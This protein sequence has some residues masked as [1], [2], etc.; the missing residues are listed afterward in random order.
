[1]R[2]F[3]WFER[4]ERH[5]LHDKR[6][7]WLR[8][9]D[10]QLIE[11]EMLSK[12]ERQYLDKLGV[13]LMDDAIKPQKANPQFDLIHGFFEQVRAGLAEYK[14][15]LAKAEEPALADLDRLAAR[16]YCRPLRA[17]EA[18]ALRGLY[19]R[20]RKQGHGV[21]ASLRG[22]FTAVLM[23]PHFFYRVP[24]TPAGKGVYPLRD[25]AMARRISYFLWSS[26]P[27]D[28][29]LKSARAGELQDGDVLRTQVR[30]MMKD[31]KIEALAREFFGQWLRYRD[32]PAKDT[33][34]AKTFPGYDADLRAA[35]FEEPTRLITHLLQEDNSVDELLH[36]DA[37]FVNDT[38]ARFY[39]G[40]IEKQY[41]Q[42]AGRA[43]DGPKR[44]PKSEWH[45]VEGLRDIGRG[46]LFGMPVILATNSVGA[47]TSPVKRGFW[48]VHHVLGQH[49]PPPPAEVP[50]LPKSEK[51]SA[52]TIREMLA[53]HTTKQSCAMCHVH[54][55][56]LGLTMEGF[57]AIGRARK[58]D[59]AGRDVLSV[60]P[61]PGGKNVAGI[62][63]LIEYIET[64]RRQEFER[65]LCR[66][67]LGYALGRSVILSDEPLVEEM[68]KKLR[69]ERRF[70]VLFETVVLSPQ[71]RR[72]RGRDFVAATR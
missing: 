63:G 23:S 3:V 64:D 19:Q 11:E 41:R 38:L 14:Q 31:A 70:S 57:D 8:S 58:K 69:A 29:L 48:V 12:F 37:T 62:S 13:K 45:R 2:G 33:I 67:I 26:L 55:D 30:R 56:G 49:F 21:E 18:K 16:A 22:T 20:L 54:F 27:D 52:R 51:E 68:Q 17:D 28:E 4:S 66:K 5:V 35:I 32:Y 15:T 72:Q 6:F 50:P 65:N 43:S 42:L 9:E 47:R 7:D 61:L 60:G 34:P 40:A 44:D 59:L 10:P 39:G 36:S 24:V 25:E 46:G 71:F 1:L 53:A